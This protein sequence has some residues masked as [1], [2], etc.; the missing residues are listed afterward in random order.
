[1]TACIVLKYGVKYMPQMFIVQCYSIKRLQ[2]YLRLIIFKARCYYIKLP[3]NVQ[4]FPITHG[5]V[6]SSGHKCK[7][8]QN[9]AHTS[10][11]NTY[12]SVKGIKI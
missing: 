6:Y 12:I 5:S 7:F 4:Q 8:K 9:Y 10:L 11:K 2:V 1:M 3:M